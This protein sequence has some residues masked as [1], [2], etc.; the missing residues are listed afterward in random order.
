M[1]STI[2][3]NNTQNQVSN[4]PKFF[5]DHKKGE[6]VELMNLLRNP[7][8]DRDINKKKDI[9]KRV[10]AYMTLGVDVSKLFHDMVKV[11]VSR[12]NSI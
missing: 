6:V 5:V 1:S 4:A 3:T 8:I 12:L 11:N 10:I 7:N 9:V 2:A